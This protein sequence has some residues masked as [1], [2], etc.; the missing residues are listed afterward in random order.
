MNIAPLGEVKAKFSAYIKKVQEG[1]VIV[2]KN[3]KPVVLML[4]IKDD[5]D[6][7][8]LLLAHSPAFQALLDKAEKRIQE[9][10]G[11]SHEEVWGKVS[12]ETN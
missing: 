5:D 12:V 8:C 11:L 4:Q 1:P 9:T 3:G 7:E 2:T 6:L 10:G